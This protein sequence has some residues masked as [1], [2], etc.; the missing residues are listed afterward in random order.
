MK[1]T[2]VSVASGCVLLASTAVA[3]HH[4]M[5]IQQIIG[6]VGGDVTAQ[7]IQLRQR[8]AGQNFV[9]LSRLRVYDAAGQNPIT[10]ITF[11][12]NVSNGAAGATIL[13]ASP[14]FVGKTTPAAVPDFTM[15][16]VIPASYLAAGKLAFEDGA[17]IWW[18]VAWGGAAYTGSQVLNFTNDSDSNAGP[19][20]PLALPSASTSA[21]TYNG[22]AS[23]ASTTNAANY[24]V[25]SG[26]AVFKN[27]PGTNFTV[28]IPA[29]PGDLNNDTF[30]DDSD[31]V[32]FAEAYNLLDCADPAMPSGCPADLNKDQMV[33]DSDFVLFAAA[34]D[35]LICP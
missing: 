33:D 11:P 32:I 12:A 24:I 29:C 13:I 7:A 35:A 26:A 2:I 25:T 3:S 15:S 1:T 9:A 28:T 16:A 5:Q 17:T 31:F 23:G 22:A 4:V 6:G 30:V 19:A 27:N 21:L 8:F 10:L 14:S 34:Y 20:F 18:S